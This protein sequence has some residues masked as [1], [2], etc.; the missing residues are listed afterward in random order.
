MPHH[1]TTCCYLVHALWMPHPVNN[2]TWASYAEQK[3]D[4]CGGL[5]AGWENTRLPA[6]FIAPG[7]SQNL[8]HLIVRTRQ[9]P[10]VYR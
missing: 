1:G 6:L 5:M 3:G 9:D 8:Y 10:D 4:I 7:L 2:R